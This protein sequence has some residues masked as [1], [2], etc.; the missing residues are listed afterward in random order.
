MG[1]APF[2]EFCRLVLLRIQLGEEQIPVAILRHPSSGEGCIFFQKAHNLKCELTAQIITFQS[3]SQRKIRPV[4]AARDDGQRFRGKIRSLQQPA[5]L[6]PELK[7]GEKRLRHLIAVDRCI[8]AT[9]FILLNKIVHLPLLISIN[10]FSRHRVVYNSNRLTH[11][12]NIRKLFFRHHLLHEMHKLWVIQIFFMQEAVKIRFAHAFR[13]GIISLSPDPRLKILDLPAALH[14]LI[15]HCS[16]H[17][18]AER[19]LEDQK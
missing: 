17:A 12:H 14:R 10:Q 9:L 19:A 7:F 13:Y 1:K 3:I 6:R 5:L 16:G 11:G 15:R 18:E 8:Q 2:I 4:A